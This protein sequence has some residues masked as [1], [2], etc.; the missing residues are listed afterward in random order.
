LL[1]HPT[2]AAQIAQR[3]ALDALRWNIQVAI[4]ALIVA[5]DLPSAEGIAA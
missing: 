2:H 1:R 5:G 3:R 4:A